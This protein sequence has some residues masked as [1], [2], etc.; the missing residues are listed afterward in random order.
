MPTKISP[1]EFYDKLAP[2]YDSTLKGSK[3]NARYIYEAAK[4]FHKYYE[5]ASGSILDLGCGTGLLK[6]LLHGELQYTGIDIAQ[7]MLHYASKRGYTVCH[8][9][10]EEALPKIRGTSYD[11]VFALGSLLF[12]KDIYSILAH[13]NRIARQAVILSLDHLTQEYIDSFK[14]TVFDHSKILIPET[15]EDYSIRGWSSPT[16]GVTVMTRIIYIPKPYSQP[17]HLEAD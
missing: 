1:Q 5:N 4:V 15:K 17:F 9:S 12:V 8:K 14:V 3:V 10:V 2:N 11:F 13:I 7:K 16:T 6:D